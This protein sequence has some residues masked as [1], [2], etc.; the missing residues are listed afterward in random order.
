METQ[1]PDTLP[2]GCACLSCRRYAYSSGWH[3][4][5]FRHTRLDGKTIGC[6]SWRQIVGQRGPSKNPFGDL[7]K[8]AGRMLNGCD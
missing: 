8:V 6:S 3:V 1:Y 7:G 2:A 5:K 4:C